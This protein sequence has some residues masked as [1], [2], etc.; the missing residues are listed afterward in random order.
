MRPKYFLLLSSLILLSCGQVQVRRFVDNGLPLH[1]GQKL[2]FV[3]KDPSLDFK[4]YDGLIIKKTVADA[5]TT[6]AV[7]SESVAEAIFSAYCEEIKRAG[8]FK[9]VKKEG[10]EISSRYLVLESSLTELNPGSGAARYLLGFGAGAT[11]IQVEGKIIDPTTNKTLF[12]Y[13]DRRAGWIG[14]FGGRSRS[15]ILDDAIAHAKDVIE[16]LKSLSP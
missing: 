1:K 6:Q 7:G 12:A 8:I 11:N 2:D 5:P 13:V 4:A 3:Y 9:D 14:V 16:E 15:L 10:E